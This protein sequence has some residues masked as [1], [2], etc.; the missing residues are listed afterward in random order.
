MNIFR[1]TSFVVLT[2]ALTVFHVAEGCGNKSSP[3]K[4]LSGET[5]TAVPKD[6][7]MT[8]ETTAS[9]QEP[10]GYA[11]MAADGTIELDLR[12]TSDGAMARSVR[13]LK[14]GDKNYDEVIHHVGG[15]K[16]GESKLVY[17]WH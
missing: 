15:L 14:P 5:H 9:K 11:R 16:P 3:E 12:R 8:N 6:M 1:N 2:I 7:P 17:P 4:K 13:Q 10:I